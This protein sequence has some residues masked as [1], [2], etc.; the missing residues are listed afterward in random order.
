MKGGVEQGGALPLGDLV[1]AVGDALEVLRGAG[2]VE[3]CVAGAMHPKPYTLH[4]A[5]YTPHPT[6]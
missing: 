2:W 4:P 1:V 5:P 6:P 3:R